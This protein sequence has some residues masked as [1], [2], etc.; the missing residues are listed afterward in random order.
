MVP[1]AALHGKEDPGDPEKET[2]GAEMQLHIGGKICRR[3]QKDS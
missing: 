3:A 1:Q 2:S